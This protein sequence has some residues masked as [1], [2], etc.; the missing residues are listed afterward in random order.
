MYFNVTAENST[1]TAVQTSIENP[2]NNEE[3]DYSEDDLSDDHFDWAKYFNGNIDLVIVQ[4]EG[5]ELKDIVSLAHV[6]M[7]TADQTN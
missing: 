1:A 3:S 6:Y 7:I 4:T 5:L 2:A